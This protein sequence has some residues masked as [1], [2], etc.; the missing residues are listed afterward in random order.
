MQTDPLKHAYIFYSPF[1][2]GLFWNETYCL[3]NQSEKHQF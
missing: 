2:K 1:G 3:I